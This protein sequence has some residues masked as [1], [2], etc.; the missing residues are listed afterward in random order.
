M[1]SELFGYTAGAFTGSQKEHLGIFKAA[2]N[3]SVFLD[4]FG[5]I[6]HKMQVSLLRV[7]E[8]K[9]I[10]KIGSTFSQQIHCKILIATNVDLQK[11]VFDK[12]FRED[13]YYRL[14]RFEIKLPP[15]R[16]R[17]EDIP[18]ILNYFLS[19]FI[20]PSKKNIEVSSELLGVLLTYHWPGNI[21]E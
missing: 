4:K 19:N 5:D 6:S 12:K 21:R 8:S 13:L 14:V 17:I 15:L 11:S 1:Q 3:G 18:L 9:E 10:R 20:Y 16:S 2:K 7:L